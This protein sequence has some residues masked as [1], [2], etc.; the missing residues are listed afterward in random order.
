ML[1]LQQAEAESLTGVKAFHQGLT[2][3]ALGQT[4]TGAKGVLDASGKRE[5][6]I[7][8]RLADGL[9]KAG[10][11]IMAMNAE[12][13]ED[14]EI[15]RITDEDFVTINRENLVGRFDLSLDISSSEADNIKA[16]ELAFMLQTVGPKAD[17]GM[18]MMI[19]A[20]I[21]R[22]RK[23]HELEKKLRNY[24]PQPDP[25][26]QQKIMLEME[27]LKAEIE[28]LKAETHNQKASGMLDLAKSQTEQAKARQLGG[29]ADK[30]DLDF[31]DQQTGKAHMRDLEKMGAQ[32]R[33]NM[34][35]KE[36]EAALKDRSLVVGKAMDSEMMREHDE[37]LAA[38][39]S[40]SS[41]M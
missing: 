40:Q 16:Q 17:I 21:A 38:N 35:L 22:L 37:R 9:K 36:K 18:Q 24:Q 33:A 25:M 13:L 32:A 14:S 30:L 2:G 27:K 31:L 10:Y 1:Q 3:D 5:L 19:M 6:G 12:F 28:K 41:G 29:Q 26:Q 23:M 7:L 15:I 34:Q 20:D 11:K 39:R 4:A 8:R